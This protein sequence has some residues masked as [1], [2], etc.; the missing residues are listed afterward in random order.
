MRVKKSFFEE[1]IRKKSE[2]NHFAN[3]YK[4]GKVV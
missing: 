1:K 3:S 2:Q 4:V